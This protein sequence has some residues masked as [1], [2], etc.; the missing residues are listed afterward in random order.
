MPS[1]G[2]QSVNLTE[3]DIEARLSDDKAHLWISEA[4]KA[5]AFAV[6]SFGGLEESHQLSGLA[7]VG[8]RFEQA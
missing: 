1:I 7:F 2:C 5:V 8:H 3:R 4:Q 6:V